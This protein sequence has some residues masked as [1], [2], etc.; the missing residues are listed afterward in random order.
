MLFS[1]NACLLLRNITEKFKCQQIFITFSGKVGNCIRNNFSE[2]GGILDH[3]LDREIYF[4][5]FCVCVWGGGGGGVVKTLQTNRL[6][7]FHEM[8]MIGLKWYKQLF[9]R[10]CSFLTHWDGVMHICI[11]NLGH[12]CLTL[13]HLF[14]TKPLSDTVPAYHWLDPWE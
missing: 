6:T 12:H 3:Y 4:K 13:C 1:G 9:W 11:S 8:F 10:Y 5:F 14:G 2:D 7:D